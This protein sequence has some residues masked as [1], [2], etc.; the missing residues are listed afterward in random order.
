[1]YNFMLDAGRRSFFEFSSNRTLPLSKDTTL[2][3][4]IAASSSGRRSTS[5]MLVCSSESVRVVL[6]TR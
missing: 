6:E 4:T 5:E 2:I 1:V 3:P